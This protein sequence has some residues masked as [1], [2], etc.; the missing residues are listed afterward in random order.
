MRQTGIT[1]VAD[2]FSLGLIAYE[3]AIGELPHTRA[4]EHWRLS[5]SDIIV[6]L[7]WRFGTKEWKPEL[8]A[9]FTA[10]FTMLVQGMLKPFS[11]RG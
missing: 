3:W 10:D 11:P 9:P 6:E 8:P 4:C 2:V 5:T 1:S 7:K